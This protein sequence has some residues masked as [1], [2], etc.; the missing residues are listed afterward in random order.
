MIII[1]DLNIIT[2]DTPVILEIYFIMTIN[3]IHNFL[4]IYLL[5]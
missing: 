5:L 1:F 2:L 4:K 3:V